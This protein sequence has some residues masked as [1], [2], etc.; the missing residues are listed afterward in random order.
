[1]SP[2][3]LTS[4]YV[5]YYNSLGDF[6]QIFEKPKIL[7]FFFSKQL[8]TENSILISS[9]WIF[10]L[11]IFLLIFKNI[12]LGITFH[13][14]CAMS[15]SNFIHVSVKNKWPKIFWQVNSGTHQINSSQHL[16]DIKY[17]TQGKEKQTKN[18]LVSSLLQPLSLPQKCFFACFRHLCRQNFP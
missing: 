4:A 2:L 7:F 11:L 1:M 12:Y 3:I 5:Y 18:A 15:L 9:L 16:A 6:L 17:K 13:C 14:V 8:R 10:V